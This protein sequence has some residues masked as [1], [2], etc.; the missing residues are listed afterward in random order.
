MNPVRVG[1]LSLFLFGALPAAAQTYVVHRVGGASAHGFDEVRLSKA[2]L[3]GQQVRVWWA[4][5]LNPDC[6]A[7]GTMTTRVVEPPRHGQV[8]ISDD[9]FFPG[10]VEP[11][12]RAACDAKKAPGKQAFYTAEPDFHGHDRL[13]LENAT[14]EGRIRRIAIDVE[15]R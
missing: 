12:P 7:A 9:P 5:M 14:S 13:V 2:A 6:S 4:M 1:L 10:F 8:A 11:N 3:A 15:V